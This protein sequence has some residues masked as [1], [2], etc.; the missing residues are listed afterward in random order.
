MIGGE[1]YEK[2]EVELDFAGLCSYFMGV[3]CE[4]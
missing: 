2:V 4:K 3:L 1:T